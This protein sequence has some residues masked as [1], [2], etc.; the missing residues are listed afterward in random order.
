MMMLDFYNTKIAGTYLQRHI[1][2]SLIDH[3][4]FAVFRNIHNNDYDKLYKQ[5]LT[6]LLLSLDIMDENMV[7]AMKSV[8]YFSL[9]LLDRM[10]H[11]MLDNQQSNELQ[12]LNNLVEVYGGKDGE[13]NLGS[14]TYFSVLKFR[15]NR[16]ILS[17]GEN[18]TLTFDH[19]KHISVDK[20]LDNF[21]VIP[22]IYVYL[23]YSPPQNKRKSALG[24]ASSISEK[25]EKYMW[26]KRVL[27]KGYNAESI[28]DTFSRDIISIYKKCGFEE[29]RIIKSL[30]YSKLVISRF[31]ERRK[32]DW[33]YYTSDLYRLVDID[34]IN[35]QYIAEVSGQA[36]NMLTYIWLQFLSD[37]E[38]DVVIKE[39]GSSKNP[40]ILTD[41]TIRTIQDTVTK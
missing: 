22:S 37:K 18:H 4:T 20:F 15:G 19:N 11:Q 33:V 26:D 14:L 29:D 28:I 25:Y 30:N 12:R 23:E 8:K 39:N 27:Y 40:V 13:Y 9:E 24:I 35:R 16:M 7:R 32:D 3:K 2:K 21:D 1:D 6:E 38:F 36:H 31:V 5:Y 17:F 41:N 10:Y 34:L